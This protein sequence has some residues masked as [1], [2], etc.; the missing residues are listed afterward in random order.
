MSLF[1]L[2]LSLITYV[3][4]YFWARA[5]R[6][7]PGK[8]ESVQFLFH[9]NR[10]ELKI[11]LNEWITRLPST[12]ILKLDSTQ[13]IVNQRTRGLRFGAFY[14]FELIPVPEGTLIKISRQ[15]KLVS[16]PISQSLL[17]KNIPQLLEPFDVSG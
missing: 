3:I 15:A 8:Y 13:I 6:P 16:I 17:I 5:T 2:N 10:E 12:S 14:F 4:G 1:F 7:T 11:C 9:G